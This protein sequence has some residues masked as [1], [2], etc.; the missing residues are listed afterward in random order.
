MASNF[1]P[2]TV[3]TTTAVRSTEGGDAYG[4]ISFVYDPGEYPEFQTVS[5]SDIAAAL[6]DLFT[7][8][9]YT[10][11]QFTAPVTTSSAL[12]WPQEG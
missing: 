10:F 8:R 4:Q 11:D 9:G 5:A 2:G 7:S 12:D 3:F 6:R 1:P